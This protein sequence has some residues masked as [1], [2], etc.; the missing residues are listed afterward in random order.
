MTHQV[1]PVSN[2]TLMPAAPD[3][4]QVCAANHTP[5]EPHNPDSLYWQTA[6]HIAGED[7]PTWEL[8]LAHVEE[9]LRQ[10]WVDELAKHG[11]VVAPKADA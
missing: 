11:I 3:A 9:P 2:W 7:P 4:C 5:E 8:A 10:G 1:M 6:R